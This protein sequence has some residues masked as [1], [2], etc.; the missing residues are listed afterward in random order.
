MASQ[1]K[2]ENIV[3]ALE[4]IFEGTEYEERIRFLRLEVVDGW[5]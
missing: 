1:N 2:I 5:G 3:R 4:E